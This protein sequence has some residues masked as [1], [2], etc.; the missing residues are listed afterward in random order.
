MTT[1]RPSNSAVDAMY[2]FQECLTEM[3]QTLAHLQQV[4]HDMSKAI[5][6]MKLQ[7][8]P[9]ERIMVAQ[10]MLSDLRNTLQ[11]SRAYS[12]PMQ[13]TVQPSAYVA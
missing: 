2:Q 13:E 3:R 12:A 4:E 5:A 6:E 8:Q 10:M 11:T 1:E 9:R 7:N